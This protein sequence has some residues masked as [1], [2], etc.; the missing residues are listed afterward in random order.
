M[1]GAD[2]AITRGRRATIQEVARRAGVS[3]ATVSRV[4]SGKTRVSDELAARVRAVADELGYR[5][6]FAAR[7]LALGTTQMVG[8]VVPN[9]ANPYFYQVIKSVNLAAVED[10]YQIAVADT[11]ED[12]EQELE[13][14]RSFV[15]KLD[16]LL[17]MSPRMPTRALRALARET[18]NLVLLNRVAPEVGVPTVAIDSHGAMLELCGHLLS[19]GHRRAVYLAGPASSWSNSERWRAVRQARSFGLEVEQVAAGGTIEAGYDAVEEALTHRASA[20]ICHNDLVAF[21]ALARLQELGV[22]VPDDVSL[23]GFDDIP[24]ASYGAPSLTT[25]RSEEDLGLE[26]WKL[27]SRVVR[28]EPLDDMRL[29]PARVVVRGS[30]A[31]PHESA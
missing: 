5:P 29:L 25:V 13:L 23:T 28:G 21:G 18:S 3:T 22:R 16:G 20:I 10:G 15:D 8:M 26:G 6:S 1:S 2:W 24:F 7:S 19:L 11:N 9:L 14:C 31:A 12:A 17:L 30:T 27:M 4:M